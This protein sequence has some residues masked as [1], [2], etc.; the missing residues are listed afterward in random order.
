MLL[1]LGIVL[2][3]LPCHQSISTDHA[4][5]RHREWRIRPQAEGEQKWEEAGLDFAGDDLYPRVL[6]TEY[7]RDHKQQ[8]YVCPTGTVMCYVFAGEEPDP[9]KYGCYEA[10][11]VTWRQVGVRHCRCE[12]KADGKPVVREP[13]NKELFNIYESPCREHQIACNK[14][15]ATTNT[16]TGGKMEQSP[17]G[18]YSGANRVHNAD[19]DGNYGYI[20]RNCPCYMINYNIYMRILETTIMA[21]RV[22][23]VLGFSD[24]YDAYSGTCTGM[25]N[26]TPNPSQVAFTE[27]YLR[28]DDG[29]WER[30]NYACPDGNV[31]CAF[32]DFYACFR[33]VQRTSDTGCECKGTSAANLAGYASPYIVEALKWYSKERLDRGEET[34]ICGGET[35]RSLWYPDPPRFVY[36]SASSF[37]Y[38][39]QFGC[40]ETIPEPLTGPGLSPRV[41]V[42]EQIY[43][44][45]R[46]H[47]VIYACEKPNEYYC[48]NWGR[49]HKRQPGC[50]TGVKYEDEKHCTCV[51]SDGSA[52][53][54]GYVPNYD[55]AY[56]EVLRDKII[57][58][59]SQEPKPGHCGLTA[60]WDRPD[61]L[62]FHQIIDSRGA[63]CSA[64]YKRKAGVIP[65]ESTDVARSSGTD[66]RRRLAAARRAEVA[67]QAINE[68]LHM[69]LFFHGILLPICVAI[70]AL[71][72]WLYRLEYKFCSLQQMEQEKLAN[73]PL[74]PDEP[75][76]LRR[77]IFT[78]QASADEP[79][80]VV[81]CP[82]R[83]VACFSLD[84]EVN[85]WYAG[86]Y[87]YQTIEWKQTDEQHCTCRRY[88]TVRADLVKNFHHVLVEIVKAPR[89]SLLR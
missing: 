73:C 2:L 14:W 20:P 37:L 82:P 32:D 29:K 4:D 54:D 71:V 88:P 34:G 72:Y 60:F 3:F 89:V 28:P 38:D 5:W 55:S 49:G 35:E 58:Q 84:G 22:C 85:L 18:C 50:Y 48:A 21:N 83:S 66:E 7:I 41:A 80:L 13:M 52:S 36:C 12:K 56:I 63:I 9:K 43:W 40:G 8:I 30:I 45:G 70:T 27:L 75:N 51:P 16:T 77:V 44:N 61:N 47:D 67:Q 17:L 76:Y 64:L 86:C 62:H 1:E 24:L 25:E 46:R 81:L 68:R 6:F 53:D 39:E 15:Q 33:G 23:P 10:T 59:E 19:T 78:K 26:K 57:N 31:F 69:V 42:R 87:H 79:V 74:V 11:S 65:P